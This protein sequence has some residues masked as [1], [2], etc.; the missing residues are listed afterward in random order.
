M[1]LPCACPTYFKHRLQVVDFNTSLLVLEELELAHIYVNVPEDVECVAEVEARAISQDADGDYFENGEVVK[2]PALAQ[3]EWVAGQKRYTIK[4]LLPGDEGRGV[5]KVYAGPRGLMHSNKYN[6][7]SLALG[8]PISHTGSNPPFSFLTLHPTPH[9]QRHDLYVA[10][11]QCARL[12]QNNT[13]VFNVRQHPASL[14]RTP[15]ADKPINGRASPQP[16]TRPTSALSMTSISV[17]GSAY[18]NPSQTS[19][20]G[21]NNPLKPAKLAI[22]T[23][24]GKIIRL[25]RKSEH[26]GGMSESADGSVWETVIKIGEKGVWRG[27]VLADRSARWCVFAEWECI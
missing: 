5:L 15:D 10:Q 3:A 11:P 20:N 12:V 26:M 8:L 24:T 13:F 17:S 6:P 16:F 23:P 7:H 18:S 4:A 27:L 2:K 19:S 25:L 1:A 9:A 21:S 22:Q 14:T